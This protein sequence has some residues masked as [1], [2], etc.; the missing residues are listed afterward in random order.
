MLRALLFAAA[1]CALSGAHAARAQ[2]ASA[3]F[4]DGERAFAAG[5]YEDALRLFSAARAAGSRG[6][7]SYYNIGVSQYRLGEYR[8]AGATFASLAVAFPEWRELAEYNRGLALRA[9]GRTA[10]ARLAFSRALASSDEKIT[11]LARAQLAEL[12]APRAARWSGYLAGGLGYDDNVALFDE[13]LLPS[14][15]SASSPLA[16]ALGILTRSFA[17]APLRVDASGYWVRYADA[18]EYDQSAVRFSLMAEHTVGAWMLN[19]GPTL[20]RTML[21]GDGFEELV[22]A[23]LRLRRSFGTNLAFDA[24][25][26]YDDANAGD[27]RFA[28]I[29]GSRRQVRLA[30]Q[31]SA[32]ARVRFGYDLERNDRADAGVSPSRSRWSVSYERPLSASW[33]LEAAWSHR[34]SRYSKASTPREEQLTQVTL[35]ARRELPAA[36]ALRAEYRWSDNDS[37]VDAFSYDGHRASASLSRGF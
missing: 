15:Q 26:V 18:D 33:S 27:A 6:P 1:C 23:D 3:L 16:E 7:G 28:Y 31:R 12:G 21:D 36:W 24:R 10:E 5:Q 13:L 34:T 2:D 17:A 25:V 8:D 9:D 37:T 4:A 19:G 22:G 35:A 14:S 30:V 29:D 32:A 20:A 11:A